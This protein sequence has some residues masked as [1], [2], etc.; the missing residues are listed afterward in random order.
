MVQHFYSARQ[1]F[2]LILPDTVNPGAK[3][4]KL[5]VKLATADVK[6]GR[7]GFDLKIF[8]EKPHSSLAECFEKSKY[9]LDVHSCF[10][11]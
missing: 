4:M 10:A 1:R 2:G 3:G 8:V 11:C 5:T 6:H 9:R 7:V